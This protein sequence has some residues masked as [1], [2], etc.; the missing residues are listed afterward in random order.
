MLI[1]YYYYI[2]TVHI[3]VVVIAVINTITHVQPITGHVFD[4]FSFHSFSLKQI[5][6]Y[7]RSLRLGRVRMYARTDS[8]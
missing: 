3:I 8:V 6:L 1:N 7:E 5:I 4:L 2:V